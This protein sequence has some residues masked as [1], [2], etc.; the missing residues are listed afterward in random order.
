MD[1]GH[2]PLWLERKKM[3]RI[4]IVEDEIKIR[5]VL[6]D[7]LRSEGYDVSLASDGEAALTAVREQSPDLAIL[8]VML[9]K[10]NGFDVCRD[11]RAQGVNLPILMLTAKGEETDKVLGLELGAD[12]YMTK[13]F[14]LKELNSRIRALLRRAGAKPQ[15]VE[16]KIR[17]GAV[18]IDFKR[19]IVLRGKKTLPLSATEAGLM[20]YFIKHKGEVVSREALL[21]RIWG[22]ERFPTTRT[23]DTHVLNLR[24]K[25]EEHPDNPEFILTVHGS[26][27]RLNV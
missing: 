4:L 20:E 14:G 6:A 5:K 26:G 21:N 23:I 22:Y 19:Q 1:C 10:K 17:F 18:T 24:K 3:E 9:P 12:D 15:A 11:L 16:E 25:I 7:F 27:Y 13:P 8:D 2:S